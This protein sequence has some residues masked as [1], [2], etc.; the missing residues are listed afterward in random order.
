M[1]VG[2]AESFIDFEFKQKLAEQLSDSFDVNCS[3]QASS[4][5]FSGSVKS[6]WFSPEDISE[7]LANLT[8]FERTRR[9]SVSLSNMSSPSEFNPLVFEISSVDS[10]GHLV[11]KLELLR[12]SYVR[13]QLSPERMSVS[14]PLDG[15]QLGAVLIEFRKLFN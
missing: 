10:A 12:I 1:R 3:V 14:F 9:G 6:I 4:N 2:D 11:V 7:F 8:K 5:G 15:E 13:D